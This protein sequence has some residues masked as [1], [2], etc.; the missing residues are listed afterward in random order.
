MHKMGFCSII[1][2]SYYNY[3]LCV[4]VFIVVAIIVYSTM[5]L[6]ET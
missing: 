3:I 5:C 4:D 6:I 2:W 1:N